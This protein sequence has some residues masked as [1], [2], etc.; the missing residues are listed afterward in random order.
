MCF[1]IFAWRCIEIKSIY[2]S[3][4]DALF[5]L[6]LYIIIPVN[7][8]YVYVVNSDS[9]RFACIFFLLASI[10]Y[11]CYTRINENMSKNKIKIVKIIGIIAV[12][13]TRGRFCCVDKN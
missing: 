2:K 13:E 9:G 3:F 1:L 5:Y 12:S 4:W 6:I 10:L 7:Q 8:A 11:D